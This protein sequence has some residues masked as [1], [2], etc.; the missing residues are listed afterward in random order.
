MIDADTRAL[1]EGGSA[2][3]VGSVAPDGRPHSSRAWALD[4]LVDDDVCRVRVLLDGH[5]EAALANLAAGRP[6]AVTGADVVSLRSVQLKGTSAG[7]TSSEPG[8]AERVARHTRAFFDDVEATDGTPRH[9]LERLAPDDVVAVEI[10]V[11]DV[12]DQTPGPSAGRSLQV[13]S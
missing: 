4:V 12:F 1:L 7:V 8:D 10:E 2:L 3:I 11:A 13:P 9:V 5:D 6:V